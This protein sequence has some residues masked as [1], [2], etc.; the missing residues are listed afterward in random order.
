MGA[1][2]DGQKRVA[3]KGGRKFNA[4]STQGRAILAARGARK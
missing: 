4:T 2:S 3:S 1:G